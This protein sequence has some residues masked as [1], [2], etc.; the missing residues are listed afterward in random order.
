[1]AQW[2]KDPALLLLWYKFEPWPGNFHMLQALCTFRVILLKIIGLKK[3]RK[4]ESMVP[5]SPK[6]QEH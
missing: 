5:P 1:M 6:Y 3:Q 2:V 4:R